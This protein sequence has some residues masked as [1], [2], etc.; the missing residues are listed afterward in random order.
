MVIGLD[1]FPVK[2]AGDE[3]FDVIEHRYGAEGVYL[4]LE[5]MKRIYGKS[6][7]YISWTDDL[8]GILAAKL[9][10][11]EETVEEMVQAFVKH[12][13]FSIPMFTDYG[14]LT[15]AEIQEAYFTATYRRKNLE[16]IREYII[17]KS[18]LDENKHKI[19]EL[20]ECGRNVGRNVER[21]VERYDAPKET[22]QNET[23][24]KKV[25]EIHSSEARTL[26]TEDGKNFVIDDDL[27][28]GLKRDFKEVDVDF[29]VDRIISYVKNC[30]CRIP[31]SRAENYIRQSLENE[32]LT[33]NER[34][35]GKN[36]GSIG[37]TFDVD[38][39]FADAL[40]SSRQ[41]MI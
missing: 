3:A 27:M 5:L 14:I 25:N 31:Y 12:R 30:R 20:P 26:P 23:K 15:S 9:R 21:N 39:F 6:G 36:S 17:D 38:E 2:S 1:F 10:T 19:T 8:K 35:K 11:D 22:K 41:E 18:K 32:K 13:I 33:I 7:Y 29:V 28:D 16:I 40:E 37:S 24:E 34:K 4:W